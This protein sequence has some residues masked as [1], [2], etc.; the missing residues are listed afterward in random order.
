MKLKY[1]LL[2]LLTASFLITSCGDDENEMEQEQEPTPT[3]QETILGTWILESFG[4]TCTDGYIPDA[5]YFGSNGCVNIASSSFCSEL[6]LLEDKTGTIST[7]NDG[8]P[9]TISDITFTIDET[10]QTVTIC[11]TVGSEC[12]DFS[13]EDEKLSALDIDDTCTYKQTLVKD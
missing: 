6:I 1:L 3:F 11:D 12:L 5:E 7:S 10:E 4:V 13:L 2:I 8:N 9:A